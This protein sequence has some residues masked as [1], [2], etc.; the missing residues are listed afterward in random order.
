MTYYIFG[1]HPVSAA[2]NNPKRTIS[3]IL[4][5]NEENVKLIETFKNIPIKRLNQKSMDNILGTHNHQGI[6]IK[7]QEIA[8]NFKQIEI[9]ELKKIVILDRIT[10]P[11]NF[12]AIL[13]SAAFFG[14]DLII[15]PKDN[16]V[17]ES[18]IVAKTSAGGIE[19]IDITYVTNIARTIEILKESRFWVI[20]FEA[21]GDVMDNKFQNEKICLVFGS[22]GDG[23]RMLTKKLCDNI[24]K[25]DSKPNA[26]GQIN[27]IQSLNVSVAASLAF[28]AF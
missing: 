18:G 9:G 4:I 19:H 24:Y 2:L 27:N 26:K 14:I 17:K 5:S 15:L 22:E 23:M 6:A 13:R 3:E 1:K 12:G 20:G 21:D 16:S 10:D 28:F 7:T 25:I 8:R 11:H